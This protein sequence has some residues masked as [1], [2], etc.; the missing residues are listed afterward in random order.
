MVGLTKYGPLKEF[1][2]GQSAASVTLTIAELDAIV[3]LPAS[4]KRFE[5]WWSNDDLKTTIHAQ[6]KA[7]QEAGFQAEP[8][9]RGKRVTFRRVGS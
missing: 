2:A 6:S 4:A 9:L 1:L 7:W 3:R 8:N 5:F